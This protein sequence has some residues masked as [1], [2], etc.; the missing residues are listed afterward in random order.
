MAALA[1]GQ[2]IVAHRE[3][4]NVL[5]TYVELNRP[6]EWLA[7]IDFSDSRAAM[8]T[9]AGEFDGWAPALTALITEGDTP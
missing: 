8:Q 1:P 3:A 5:H 2:G 9:I 4:G 6:A 7:A